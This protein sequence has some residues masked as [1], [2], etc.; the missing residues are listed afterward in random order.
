MNSTIS[1]YIRDFYMDGVFHTHVSMI[2]PKGRFL[3]DKENIEVFWKK[4][5][6]AVYD[7]NEPILGLAEKPQNYLPI[8][9][10]FDIKLIE[11]DDLIIYENGHIYNFNHVKQTIEIF[12]SVLRNIVEGC[13]DDN[14][15]CVVLEKP[16]YKISNNNTSYVKNGYHLHF[17][18]IFL[19]KTSIETQVLPR[20]KNILKEMDVFADLGFNDSSLLLDSSSPTVPW[21]MYGSS[22]SEKMKP[23]KVS[24]I[25]N[26]IGDE[27]SLEEAFK[28]YQL[29]HGVKEQLL[30]IH[31]KIEYYLPRILS[32][33]ANNRR[34]YEIKYGI[35]SPLKETK[36]KKEKNDDMPK[37]SVI[38]NLKISEQL[39]PMLA[40]YRCEEY[41]EW[42]TIGWVMYN[43]G[44]GCDQALE[45][46]LEFSA[47]DEK[48]FDEATCL[49][50]WDKMVKKDFSIGTLKYYAQIDNP[51]LY[52]K[53]KND[54]SQKFVKNAIDGSHYD[55]A[56]LLFAEY[57]TEFVCSSI[58]NKT[59]YQFK[60]HQ[61]EE[62]EEGIFLRE[63]ISSEVVEKFI[64]E[65]GDHY[66]TLNNTVGGNDKTAT[67][68]EQKRITKIQKLI[69]NLKSC[70]FKNNVMNE[71]TNVFYNRKFKSLLDINPYLIGFQNGVYDL[72]LNIFRAGRPEDYLSKKMPINYVEFEETDNR[73]FA[74]YDFLEKVF[75]DS[76]LR[77]YFLDHVSDVFVGGNHQKVIYFWTGDGDNG[78]SVT[79]TIIEKML[80][81]YAIKFSTTLITG[82][83]PA[84]GTANPEL[85]RAGGGVRWAVLEE[86][87]KGEEIN[88]GYMKS[89][90]GN[91]TFWSRDL[92]EKGK[93]TKEIC[94]LF[95]LIFI[96]NTLPR[97]RGSTDN[98]TW[99]R[100]RVIPFESTFVRAGKSCPV[101]YEE[102]L[103][104]KKFPMDTDF[105]SK[106]PDL[107]EP[108]AWV[109]L[110]HRQQIKVRIEPE[111]VR[112]ATALYQKR[113][114]SYRQFIEE[115]IVKDDTSFITLPDLHFAYKDWYKEG[116]PGSQ[117]PTKNDVCEYF[118]KAWGEHDNFKWR[119]F[120]VKTLEDQVEDGEAFLLEET[121][122]VQ[123]N[124]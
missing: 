87:D 11:T 60:H 9:A 73:V 27:V 28:S 64:K 106:I 122:L 8:L 2:Q 103:R 21:L 111:K 35:I 88:I 42:I 95:K 38:E 116:F 62:I 46:W 68:G 94:P 90:T 102:Q 43:I 26:S 39:L 47:R 74:V 114:D 101:T 118:N 54:E 29:F 41:N 32:T 34:V 104:E 71:A 49:S 48:K 57:S 51:E 30:N 105:T 66:Q 25:I 121:D 6:D 75:P 19:E 108:F 16:V 44:E 33:V 15:L 79:Q 45:Q 86:P 92:F 4:Y 77:Q 58:S 67:E 40:Q 100:I 91:D 56:Q 107:L 119:G 37:L 76:S 10:D 50:E 55:I 120:R 70:P 31:G 18:S 53:F 109:L 81:E 78:K 5:C 72:K 24:K 63:K 80:G 69:A 83:K 98:A 1:N 84:T 59:W 115:L 17:P 96:C 23:Y 82:K 3:F 124:K 85:A 36:N 61:W 89:L 13:T 14:L 52:K 22:K 93:S 7:K 117:L 65:H 20:V 113:N 123:Y 99:N 12:Q 112:T 110:K 97:F